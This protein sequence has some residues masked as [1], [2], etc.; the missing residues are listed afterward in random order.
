[1]GFPLPRVTDSNQSG[2]L[3][4][5]ALLRKAHGKPFCGWERISSVCCGLILWPTRNRLLYDFRHC[6]SLDSSRIDL[7]R[8]T[9]RSLSL[10]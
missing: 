8:R 7:S 4:K 9:K 1:M 10:H 6:I 2:C 3:G 5:E